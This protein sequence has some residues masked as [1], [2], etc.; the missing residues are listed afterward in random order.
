MNIAILQT[1]FGYIVGFVI[2]YREYISET[3]S[4]RN[5]R[6]SRISSEVHLWLVT[7]GNFQKFSCHDILI[8]I[9][10]T[11]ESKRFTQEGVSSVELYGACSCMKL[12][13]HST[14]NDLLVWDIIIDL[15]GGSRFKY[16][17]FHRTRV[18]KYAKTALERS[19][20][21]HAVRWIRV[22]G[23]HQYHRFICNFITGESRNSGKRHCC[24]LFHIPGF[25]H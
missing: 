11:V 14:I 10:L 6:N 17:P 22:C 12:Y 7:T 18:V 1:S 19:S 8:R 2:A 16:D 13:I 20:P 4:C 5:E 24:I 15:E 3:K 23:T 21:W 25:W 9:F